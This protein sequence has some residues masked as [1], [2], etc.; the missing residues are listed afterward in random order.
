MRR[1]IQT[2]SLAGILA[3]GGLLVAGAS[4]AQAQLFGIS[5]PGFSMSIGGPG[6]YGGFYGGYP[7]AY[8][9]GVPY[10]GYYGGNPYGGGFYRGYGYPGYGVRSYGYYPGIGY[11]SYRTYSYGPYG[12]RRGYYGVRP[13]GMLGW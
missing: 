10:S 3:L 9:Y 6:Y 4:P 8:G 11:S 5:T 7:G 1:T 13:F 2:I 12:Y